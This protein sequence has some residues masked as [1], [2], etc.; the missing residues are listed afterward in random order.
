MHTVSN[1]IAPFPAAAYHRAARQL[2]RRSVRSAH[3][4]PFYRLMAFGWQ[5]YIHRTSN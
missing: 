3:V 4:T 1:A 5:P 2:S